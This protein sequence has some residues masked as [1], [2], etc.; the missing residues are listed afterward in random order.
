[1]TR[2]LPIATA[3]VF[4]VFALLPDS[5]AQLPVGAIDGTVF[6]QTEGAVRGAEVTARNT[7]TGL[8]RS[9]LTNDSGDFVLAQLPPGVYELTVDS[10]GFQRSRTAVI[11]QTGAA[12][13]VE[14]RLSVDV[15][16]QAV[17]A[18]DSLP[19]LRYGWHGVDGAVSRFQIENLPLNG[20]EFLQLAILQPGVTSA[21]RA[22]FF[23]RQFDVSLLG[24]SPAQTRYAVDGSPIHNPLVG[25]APQNFSQETVQEFQIQTV[26]F[27]LSTGLTAAGAVNVVTRSGGNEYHGSGFFFFRDHNLGGLS[28]AAPRSREPQP[29]LRAPPVGSARGRAGQEGPA[30]L[31]RELRAQQPRR[32]CLR[33][34]ALGGVRALRRDLPEPVRQ[35]PGQRAFRHPAQ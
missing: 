22:G 29:L 5:R 27:D 9:A 7:D 33:A 10:P 16:Q 17:E 32:R 12:T 2:I 15:L 28:G 20:R 24:A 1:M 19:E 8:S 25:G 13:R 14:V 35:H 11:V 18:L 26:N 4:A 21:P 23:T 3:F 6:D 30:V 34:A 31:L